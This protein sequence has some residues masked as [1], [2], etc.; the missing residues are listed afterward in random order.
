VL[1]EPLYASFLAITG[2]ARP[3]RDLVLQAQVGQMVLSKQQ[4]Q[5]QQ[6]PQLPLQTNNRQH[7]Q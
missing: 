2:L 6:H 1:D 7:Q 3:Y 4:Q 5:Q